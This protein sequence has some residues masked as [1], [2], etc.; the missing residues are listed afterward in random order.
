MHDPAQT[1]RQTR[2]PD[3]EP[4]A[5]AEHDDVDGPDRRPSRKDRLL[6]T[7]RAGLLLAL[8][9]HHE[10]RIELAGLEQLG[11]RARHR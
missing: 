5:V 7:E 2:L 6:K 4:V 11:R 9:E 8:D 10:I 1:K 3:A